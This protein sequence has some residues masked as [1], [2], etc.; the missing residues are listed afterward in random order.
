MNTSGTIHMLTDKDPETGEE[1][2]APL[3]LLRLAIP[4]RVYTKS[5]IDYVL[6][7]AAQVVGASGGGGGGGGTVDIS[8]LDAEAFINSNSM[9]EVLEDR[10]RLMQTY[11]KTDLVPKLVKKAMDQS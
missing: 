2:V 3:E 10:F 4:R 6:E 8:S 1:R 5:H 7:I 9:K 11:I